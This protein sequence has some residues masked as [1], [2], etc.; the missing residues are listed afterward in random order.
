MKI[1]NK[2]I[3][4]ILTAIF[5]RREGDL[6]TWLANL[7]AKIAIH[8][9]T[10]GLTGQ[11]ITDLQ[12][13]IQALI[14]QIQLAEQKKM[15]AKEATDLKKSKKKNTFANLSNL[16]KNWK[17]LTAYTTDIGKDLGIIALPDAFDE[18]NY[19]PKI[20]VA[21]E[22]GKVHVEFSKAGSD[23]GNVYS[24]PRGEPNWIFLGLEIHPPYVDTRPL[25]QPNVPEE[26]EYQVQGV[27]HDELIGQPSEI[28]S[29]V[30]GQQQQ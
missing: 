16:F 24:R 8:G 18:H 9:G 29:I 7:K 26:R 11:Q 4:I 21:I 17:T 1:I 27:K 14:D 12:N 22:G 6:V 2:I 15:D 10:L 5:P 13:E 3:H 30:V 20:S 28:V 25:R 19:K 23:G